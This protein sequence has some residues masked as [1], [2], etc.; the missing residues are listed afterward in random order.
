ME[1]IDLTREKERPEETGAPEGGAKKRK[2]KFSR[3]D[4]IFY[5]AVLAWPILQFFVFYVLTRVNAVLYSF[6]TY[7][8]LTN[9]VTWTFSHVENAFR[10]MTSE[11]EYTSMMGATL[12]FFVL[13]VGIGT[14]LGLL[15]AY[16]ISKKMFASG[17]FRVLLFLPSI[18]SAIVMATIYQFFVERA[19]PEIVYEIFGV[20]I[21]GLMENPDTRFGTIVFYNIWVGF[22]V[23]VLMY[24]NAMSGISSEVLESARLDGATGIREFWFIALPLIYPTVTTFLITSFATLF[25]NQFNIY[26]FYGGSVPAGIGTFGYYLFNATEQASS[27]AEYSIISAIGLLLT[28]IALPLTLFIRWLL[29]K[30]DPTE[31]SVQ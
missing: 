29:N 14:P 21:K 28:C 24:T 3:D 17:A 2:K 8:V 5:Y 7:D 20:R 6:Q 9:T 25:T 26:S 27:R 23:N 4:T 12:K 30:F 11:L 19:L 10:L 1:S 16:Y 22:G 13:T 15:F 31:G 18:I